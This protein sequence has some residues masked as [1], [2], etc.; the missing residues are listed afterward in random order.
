MLILHNH[1]LLGVIKTKDGLQCCTSP[2][3]QCPEDECRQP[4]VCRGQQISAQTE[5]TASSETDGS[6]SA[7]WSSAE[8]TVQKGK[9]QNKK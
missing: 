2:C 5:R 4:E 3:Q 9:V 7:S 6:G 1:S 8:S